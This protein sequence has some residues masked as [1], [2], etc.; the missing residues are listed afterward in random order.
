[1]TGWMDGRTNTQIDGSTDGW[2]DGFMEQLWK[3]FDLT[4]IP[5]QTNVWNPLEVYVGCT[6][7]YTRMMRGTSV[8]DPIIGI[9]PDRIS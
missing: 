8:Q 3:A 5:K 9:S 6:A 1:M 7:Y 2:T 4:W